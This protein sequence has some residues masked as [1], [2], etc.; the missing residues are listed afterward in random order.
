[1]RASELPIRVGLLT[2][3]HDHLILHAYL[4]KLLDVPEGE[5][6]PDVIDGTGHGWQFVEQT[7]DRALRRFYGRCAQLAVLSMDN[8]GGVDIRSAGGQEDPRHPRHW[9]HAD[10]GLHQRCRWCLLHAGAEQTRPA[11]NWLQSKPGDRWPI[12]IAVPVEAIEAWLLATRAILVPG[13]GSLHAEQEGRGPLKRRMYGRPGRPARRRRADRG[14]V[15]PAT[16]GGP[17]SGL[18]G[19]FAELLGLCGPGGP[20]P[21]GNCNGSPLLV[22]SLPS[23][24]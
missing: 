22:T 8:D 14:A 10:Q 2:E 16:W 18:E 5:L 23:S 7:I 13:S 24:G 4:A 6:E 11:L 12:V 19:P 1:M 21:R 15:D 9:L 17:D 20:T 3:G